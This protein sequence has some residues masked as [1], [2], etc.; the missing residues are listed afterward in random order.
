MTTK[1]GIRAGGHL[2]P[3]TGCDL[4]HVVRSSNDR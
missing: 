1:D 3:V 2:V 4:T